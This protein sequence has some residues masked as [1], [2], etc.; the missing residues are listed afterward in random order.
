MVWSVKEILAYVDERVKLRCGD[1]VFTGTT[2]GVGLEDGRFLQPGD[3]VEAEIEGIGVLRNTVG[4][5]PC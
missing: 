4:D 3:I 5:R 1:V 2:A